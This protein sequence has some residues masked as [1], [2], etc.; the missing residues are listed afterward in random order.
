MGVHLERGQ[1]R[2]K[3]KEKKTSQKDRIRRTAQDRHG[4]RL[5]KEKTQI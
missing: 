1:R 2:E 3:K 4:Q 5:K